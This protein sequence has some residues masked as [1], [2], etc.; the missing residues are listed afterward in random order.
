MGEE[1]KEFSSFIKMDFIKNGYSFPFDCAQGD[2]LFNLKFIIQNST[3][4]N[5]L[6]NY[7]S[8]S[9]LSTL[10]A[11]GLLLNNAFAFPQTTLKSSEFL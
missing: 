3:L 8:D 9:I 10:Q 6:I 1:K 2:K 11:S 7:V 5:L 4:S